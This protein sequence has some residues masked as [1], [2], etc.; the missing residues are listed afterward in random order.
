MADP[1]PL[2]DKVVLVTG[3]AQGLGEVISKYV[4][5]RGAILSLADLQKS[6]LDET[7]ERIRASYPDVQILTWAVNIT[8][9]KSVEEW[10]AATKE[11]FGR[12]NACVNNAGII[13][14]DPSPITD[15]SFEEWTSVI[16]VNLT[17]LFTCLKYQLRAISDDGSIV[18]MSSVAGLRGTGFYAAYAASKHGVVGLTKVAAAQHAHRGVRVNVVCPAIADTPM[19]QQL[20]DQ[21]GDVR[22]EDFPQLFKRY[23]TPDEVASMVGYLLCDESKFVTRTAFPVDG[24]YCG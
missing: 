2:K 17:G 15:L 7:A 23:V 20:R 16:D 13:G 3:A 10:V 22:V 1:K 11:K 12:I 6:K 18:N 24:G 8:D 14:K 4:A 21:T 9:P 19:W 5:A